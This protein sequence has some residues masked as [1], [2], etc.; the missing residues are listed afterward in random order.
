MLDSREIGLAF[1]ADDYFT[2][3]VDWPRLMR[4]LADMT[5]DGARTKRLL[6]IDD[7][8]AV[9]EMLEHE[10]PREGYEMQRAYSGAEG[11]K[12]AEEMKPDVITLDLSMPEMR[13]YQVAQM[14]RQ[15][16]QP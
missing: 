13:G 9:H 6:L 1:G 12:R 11:L 10:L 7:D 4:R 14:L 15:R 5:S 2:K 16:D 3:P 8:I